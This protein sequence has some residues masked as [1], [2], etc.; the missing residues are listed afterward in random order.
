MQR[1]LQ[2]KALVAFR[3]ERPGAYRHQRGWLKKEKRS[4]GQTWVL[5]FRT[6]RKSDGKRV[7]NKIS[8][9]LVKDFPDKN[10]AWAEVE[11]QRLR[12]NPVDF[13]GCLTFADLAC[14]Y[15]EHDLSE[16][17]ESIHPKAHTT[18]KGYERVLRNRLVR[19]KT[20]PKTVQTL[21]R[22][23]DVKLTLQCYTHSVSD[24]R[25]A[26]AGAMLV[27][28]FSHAGDRS[29]L[30]SLSRNSIKLFRMMV[31]RDG[32]EPQTQ[33]FQNK[34]YVHNYKRLQVAA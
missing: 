4:Q 29:G 6:V 26:A 9:G 27:A 17:T 24:D 30:R 7:E 12:I 34:L 21:L 25:M 11:K 33:P 18:I 32:V 10:C 19:I 31:A 2:V 3:Q 28:I 15:A 14:H 1:Q 5:F 8:I 13:R 22:H 20:D 16:P 23:S